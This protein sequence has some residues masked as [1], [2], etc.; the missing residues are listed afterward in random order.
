LIPKIINIGV[1]DK[2]TTK[3]DDAKELTKE[4]GC[5]KI[6]AIKVYFGE[7]YVKGQNLLQNG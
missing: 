3:F 1:P 2:R 6:N 5:I 4:G 7:K